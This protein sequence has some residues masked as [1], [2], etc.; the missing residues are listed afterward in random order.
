MDVFFSFGYGFENRTESFF[1][2]VQN[3]CRVVAGEKC[4]AVIEEQGHQGLHGFHV[5]FL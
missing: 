2:V 5:G 3:L 1:P 4:F